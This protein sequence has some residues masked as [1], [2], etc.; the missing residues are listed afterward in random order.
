MRLVAQCAMNFVKRW[1]ENYHANEKQQQHYG[2]RFFWSPDHLHLPITHD[3]V[4][5]LAFQYRT[6]KG[7]VVGQL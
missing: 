2:Y 4:S 5:T 1:E 3:S 7:D 6:V